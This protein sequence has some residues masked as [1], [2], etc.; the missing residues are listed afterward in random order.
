MAT[1]FN[2]SNFVVAQVNFHVKPIVDDSARVDEHWAVPSLA[3]HYERWTGAAELSVRMRAT[4]LSQLGLMPTLYRL[5]LIHI[6]E[7]TS[8]Y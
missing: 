4:M 6:S 2:V 3:R 8:P 1:L 7:P 5:S